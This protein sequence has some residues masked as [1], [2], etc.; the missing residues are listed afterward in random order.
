M[1]P[2]LIRIPIRTQGGPDREIPSHRVPDE[3][4]PNQGGS[5][6]VVT[7]VVIALAVVTCVATTRVGAALVSHRRASAVADVTALAAATGGTDVASA[8][9]E[10]NRAE[11][12]AL[13]QV[14]GVWSVSVV[15][16]RIT[17]ESAARLESG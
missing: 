17:A 11:V 13:K 6:T 2:K 9:A 15:R 1:N 10:A 4:V 7:L 12:I 16:E 14:G 8:V 3:R 5:V